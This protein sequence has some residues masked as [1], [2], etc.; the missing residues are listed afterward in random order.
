M[1]DARYHT[2]AQDRATCAVYGMPKAA[3]ALDAAVE[4]L[5]LPQI[6]PA[7]EKIFVPPSNRKAPAP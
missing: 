4:F 7:L 6:A 3:L 5:P 1:R 2:I